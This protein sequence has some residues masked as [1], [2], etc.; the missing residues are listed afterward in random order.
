MEERLEAPSVV[1]NP[2]PASADPHGLSAMHTRRLSA[3]D[4][5]IRRAVPVTFWHDA[6]APFRSAAGPSTS[7]S[8]V[9][10]A[11]PFS[12]Q[13]HR[14]S[15]LI[16][17]GDELLPSVSAALA[18]CDGL[19]TPSCGLPFDSTPSTSPMRST[20]FCFPLLRLRSLAPHSFPASL[21][22]LRLAPPP[23]GLHPGRW[24]LGDLAV[25]RRPIRFGGWDWVGR[26]VFS[27]DDSR[28]HRTSDIPV[29]SPRLAVRFREARDPSRPPRPCMRAFREE[30][31]TTT[32]R[33]AF[34]R[35]PPAPCA[36]RT[37]SRERSREVSAS[38]RMPVSLHPPPRTCVRWS[39]ELGARP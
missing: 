8:A 33:D 25:R 5:A 37:H 1:S 31:P 13:F 12:T 24:G 16:R 11:L 7:H 19:A 32:I 23:E 21:R 28:F 29:A 34:R 26:A 36:G 27:S 6:C 4:R 35:Q 9:R 18:V 17:F 2:L 39:G 30:P 20:N 15:L 3:P 14:P 10:T 38:R 22:G